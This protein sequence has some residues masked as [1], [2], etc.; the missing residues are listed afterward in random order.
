MAGYLRAHAMTGRKVVLADSFE[1]LPKP[2]HPQDA[3]LDLSKELHPELAIS[4]ETVEGNFRLY[5][6]LDDDVVF[7]EGWFRDTLPHAPVER[8]ALLR[9]DG[10]LY[11]S[12]MDGLRALY[13]KVPEGGV[14]IIDDFGA[15]RVCAQAV[16][17]FFEARGEPLPK[18]EKIDW[19][20]VYWIKATPE[21]E[22]KT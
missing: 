2:T 8:I 21:P 19:T 15:L 10:D 17:D 11:E 16:R 7:L 20:G 6:L 14:V 18:I 4:R 3:D 5:D 12:T 13:D 9:L 22:K 1:G